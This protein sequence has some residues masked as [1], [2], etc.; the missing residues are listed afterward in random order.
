MPKRAQRAGEGQRHD[1][2][3]DDLGHAIDRIQYR[4]AFFVFGFR[5]ASLFCSG[6]FIHV[7]WQSNNRPRLRPPRDAEIIAT[8]RTLQ[9]SPD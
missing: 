7:G 8:I 2:T 6:R 1:Q 3:E 5:H 4:R 9:A